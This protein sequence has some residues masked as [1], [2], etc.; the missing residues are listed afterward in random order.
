MAPRKRVQK[1][2]QARDCEE[3][4]LVF[5]KSFRHKSGKVVV[6]APGQVFCFRVKRKRPG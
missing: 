3:G 4:E 1:P 2:H 6:A 5:C